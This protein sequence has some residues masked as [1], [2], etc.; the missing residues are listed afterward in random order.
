VDS[1]E[2]TI[3]ATTLSKA[4]VVVSP[5]II[6]EKAQYVIQFSVGSGGALSGDDTIK[7]VFPEGTFIPSSIPVSL[8]S[9]NGHIPL[10]ITSSSLLRTITVTLPQNFSVSGGGAV[11]ISISKTVG[12]KNPNSPSNSYYLKTS[13]SKESTLIQS[14][15]YK[16]YGAPAVQLIV[17]PSS[18]DGKIQTR[19]TMLRL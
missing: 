6:G 8:I 7:I 4:F 16:I 10:S 11:A 18:P 14:N 9:V 3:S 2:Y 12:I 17:T 5:A 1:P 13:T 19:F 15:T